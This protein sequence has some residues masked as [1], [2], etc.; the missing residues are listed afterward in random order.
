MTAEKTLG[1]FLQKEPQRAQKKLHQSPAREPVQEELQQAR[2]RRWLPRSDQIY[3]VS[4]LFSN[5]S[6]PFSVK[7]ADDIKDCIRIL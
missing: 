5:G 1:G 4:S 2:I 7:W 3:S 6:S